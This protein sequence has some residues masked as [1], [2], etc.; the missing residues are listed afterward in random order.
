VRVEL[1]T[2]DG[3]VLEKRLEG[4]LGNL[5]RPLTDEQLSAK[6]RDQ[7][8]RVLSGERAERALE[9]CWNIDA[10]DDVAE[11]VSATTPQ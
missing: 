2:T 1:E 7:A 9:L 3:R 8:T 11:L 6:F 10:L 4:S 5:S